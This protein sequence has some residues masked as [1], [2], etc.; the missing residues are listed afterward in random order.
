MSNINDVVDEMEPKCGNISINQKAT[1]ILLFMRSQNIPLI[2]SFKVAASMI[3]IIE[4]D[5]EWKLPDH[6]TTE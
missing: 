2:D 3:R 6:P 1:S 4:G 5:S